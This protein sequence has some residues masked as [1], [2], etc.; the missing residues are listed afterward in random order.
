MGRALIIA[1]AGLVAL[2]ACAPPAPSGEPVPPGA[3]RL[4]SL[5]PSLTE[6]LF[7]LG[8]G[9]RLVAATEYC[10]HPPAARRLPRVGGVTSET[11]DLERVVAAEPDLVVAIGQDQGEA[12]AALRRLGLRVEVLPSDGVDDLFRTVE[13]LG[14]LVGRSEDAARLTRHLARRMA[15]VEAAVGRLPEG[16]R[17]RVF[18]QVWDDPLM[19]AGAGTYISQLIERAGGRNVFA[20]VDALYPQ[21]SPEAVIARDPEVILAP[22]M[23]GQLVEPESFARRPGWEGIEAV[24]T[25]RIHT[26]DGD[27]VARLGPRLVEALE[28]IAT[29]LHPERFPPD[30]GEAER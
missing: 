23:H 24:E 26:V 16:E 7:A 15:R 3:E 18:Y 21:V 28:S 30:P 20:D 19:T 4:V 14:T 27:R 17:P 29:I 8:A 9:E 12:I 11:L 22:R 6:I 2:G 25:G 13:R 10:D 1:V 5:A